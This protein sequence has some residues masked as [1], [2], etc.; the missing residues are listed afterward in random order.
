MHRP[1]VRVPF[2]VLVGLVAVTFTAQADEAIALYDGAGL[3]P[4][5][6]AREPDRLAEEF[7]RYSLEPQG[8]DAPHLR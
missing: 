3:A 7:V 2:L 5:D 1:S 8:G 4:W 6:A